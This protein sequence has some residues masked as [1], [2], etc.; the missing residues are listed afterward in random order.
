LA[1]CLIRKDACEDRRLAK[2][3]VDGETLKAKGKKERKKEG[4][5]SIRE[6]LNKA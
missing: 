5:C 1:K 2:V 3:E 6:G 4:R